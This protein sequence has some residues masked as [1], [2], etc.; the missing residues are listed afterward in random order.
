MDLAIQE[1]FRG[2]QIARN[3]TNKKKAP[4]KELVNEGHYSL[5]Q[6]QSGE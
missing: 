4:V 6:K 1:L 3:T 2:P 5:R